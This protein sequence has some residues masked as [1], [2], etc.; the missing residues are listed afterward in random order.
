MCLCVSRNIL[1]EEAQFFYLQIW[2]FK[3]I[4]SKSDIGINSRVY[5]TLVPS[6]CIPQRKRLLLQQFP[7]ISI[8]LL[9]WCFSWVKKIIWSNSFIYTL[10]QF[11]GQNK[12]LLRSFLTLLL[13]SCA[14][15][16]PYLNRLVHAANT[17]FNVW[18]YNWGHKKSRYKRSNLYNFYYEMQLT[19]NLL[20][21]VIWEERRIR[22]C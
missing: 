9:G 21:G 3:Y 16:Y 11:L 13:A 18:K 1:G 17:V 6:F 15:R 12:L 20:K 10:Y 5:S 7:A 8:E 19:L 2:L 4:T 14:K 22:T